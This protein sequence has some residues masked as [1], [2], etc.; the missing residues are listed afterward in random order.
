MGGILGVY[1][2]TVPEVPLVPASMS[3][4][5]KAC[6]LTDREELRLYVTN[7][8][9]NPIVD[10]QVNIIYSVNGGNLV[11]AQYTLSQALNPG[12]S[13]EYLLGSS[14]DFSSVGDQSVV[15]YTMY[16]N[17]GDDSN[18]TLDVLISHLEL[19]DP[20]GREILIRP[21]PNTRDILN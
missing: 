13:T 18:D 7:Y 14:F 11:T 4:P 15:A 1:S 17:D 8:G 5:N 2:G 10:E 16:G 6:L 9:T 3:S 21:N 20:A 19:F 12:D